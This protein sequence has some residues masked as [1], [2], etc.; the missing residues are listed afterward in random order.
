MFLAAMLPEGIQQR[1]V[2]GLDGFA[3]LIQHELDA[4]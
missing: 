3:G 4:R 2:F 1:G